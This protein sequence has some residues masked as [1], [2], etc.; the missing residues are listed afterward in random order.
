MASYAVL[1]ATSWGTTLAWLLATN[2]HSV[3][4]LTRTEAEARAVE[5]RRGLARLPEL[6]LP[7]EVTVRPPDGRASPDGLVVAVPAQSVRASIPA[8]AWLRETP[9]LCA[10]KGIE[11]G[12]GLRLTEVIAASGWPVGNLSV[13]SGPNLASEVARGLPAA[14]VVAAPQ[15]ADAQRWQRALSGRAY[16]V[17]TSTDVT[18]VQ[19]AGA[20]KNVVAIAAGV[21]TG[22][23][24]GANTLAALVTRG[25]AEITRLGTAL[26]GRSETFLG[27]AGV[28]DL[29]ATCF[30][31]LSR[32]HRL[33]QA[34]VSG[35][36]LPAALA[37]IGQVVEGVA[38]A[39]V[40]LSLARQHGIEMP[41]TAEV[42]A[43][44]SGEV[45]ARTALRNLLARELTTE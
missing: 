22:L 5:A 37:R 24:F 1:G 41:I 2:G 10:A 38:T 14:A 45:D 20:A 18:G 42:C 31:P 44:L 11:T 12:T 27:L 9:L 36:P 28:G 30:S 8:V 3:T 40:V 21:A 13:L 33:G 39:P 6:T 19:I 43:L 17:Y 35:E 15:L 4:L 29:T 25:L 34:L 23:G 16:R 32:N 26:G 7:P